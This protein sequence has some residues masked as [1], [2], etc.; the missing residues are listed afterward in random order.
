MK[1]INIIFLDLN[2]L[3]FSTLFF[4]KS[5]FNQRNSQLREQIMEALMA[6][7]LFG[8]GINFLAFILKL[9]ICH[10]NSGIV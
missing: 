4:I 2:K 9:N 10:K 3:V 8:T 1:L 7:V 5:I 6:S